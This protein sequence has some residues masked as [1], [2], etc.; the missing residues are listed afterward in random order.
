MLIQKVALLSVVDLGREGVNA[1]RV[2]QTTCYSIVQSYF[3]ITSVHKINNLNVLV[4]L[5][6]MYLQQITL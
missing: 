5:S 4:G 6:Y 1:R 2:T 3:L